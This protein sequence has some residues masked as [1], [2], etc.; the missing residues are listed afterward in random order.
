LGRNNGKLAG[1]TDDDA[2]F[3]MVYKYAAEFIHG[4]R[5]VRIW[6]SHVGIVSSIV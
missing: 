1:R 5:N 2:I 6:E 3:D 4:K